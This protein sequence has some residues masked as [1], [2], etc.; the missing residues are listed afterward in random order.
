[1]VFV[2][3]LGRTLPRVTAMLKLRQS[4]VPPPEIHSELWLCCWSRGSG[5]VVLQC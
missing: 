2:G 5:V 3:F 4:E 1:M